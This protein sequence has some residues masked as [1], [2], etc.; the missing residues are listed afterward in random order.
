MKEL[1]PRVSECFNP[2]MVTTFNN[3]TMTVLL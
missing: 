2:P 3:F 1:V